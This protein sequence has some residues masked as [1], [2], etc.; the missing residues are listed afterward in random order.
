MGIVVGGRNA[1]TS[2]QLE[3]SF[4]EV[5]LVRV[6]IKT[7][8]THQIRV[9]FAHSQH[10]VVGDSTYGGKKRAKSMHNPLVRARVVKVKR[11]M[12]HARRLRLQ[13]PV[14]GEMLDL[15]APLPD[16]M[17]FLIQFLGEYGGVG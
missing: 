1:Q 16:D 4:E 13:H 12:L 7:G 3:R 9:H 6:V 15:S 8:R 10:P 14:S 2:W 5:S 17:R 11:Q